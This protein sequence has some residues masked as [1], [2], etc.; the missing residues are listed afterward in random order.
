MWSRICIASVAFS[1]QEITITLIKT[2]NLLAEKKKKLKNLIHKKINQRS[3]RQCILQNTDRKNPYQCLILQVRS[4]HAQ[5][6]CDQ[7]NHFWLISRNRFYRQQRKHRVAAA[8]NESDARCRSCMFI[9]ICKS[10][11]ILKLCNGAGPQRQLPGLDQVGR[12]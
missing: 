11:V 5:L 6:E 8:G 10:T 9:V 4:F 2:I 7:L 1:R 3:D 12:P